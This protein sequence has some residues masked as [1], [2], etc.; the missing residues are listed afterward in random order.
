MRSLLFGYGFTIYRLRAG[1]PAF[2]HPYSMRNS[3]LLVISLGL[4][5]FAQ[6]GV[7]AATWVGGTG[8]WSNSAKWSGG[9][10]TSFADIRSGTA[11][12]TTTQLAHQVEISNGGSVLIDGGSIYT[13]GTTEDYY[14]SAGLNGSGT[15]TVRNGGNIRTGVV[16][17]G[18]FANGIGHGTVTGE[19]SYIQS[20]GQ[21][22]IGQNGVGHVNV[23]DGGALIA[24]AILAVGGFNST[25]STLTVTGEGSRVETQNQLHIGHR[26]K[27]RLTV[28]DGALVEAVGAIHISAHAGSEGRVDVTTGG[29]IEGSEHMV[30]GAF[31][32][33]ELNVTAGG[34]VNLVGM[35]AVAAYME[36]AA[37]QGTVLIGGSGSKV[38]AAGVGIGNGSITVQNGGALVSTP[39]IAVGQG[40]GDASLLVESGGTV[41]A[42]A[43]WI[44]VEDA[45][46]PTPASGQVT[47]QGL[48]SIITTGSLSIGNK[49]DGDLQIKNGGVVNVSGN[50]DMGQTSAVGTL[51]IEGAGSSLSFGERL[52]LWGANASVEVMDGGLLSG[53]AIE[54]ANGSQ[55]TVGKSAGSSSGTGILD[56][57]TIR[58]HLLSNATLNIQLDPASSQPFYLTQDGTATGDAITVET[59]VGVNITGGLAIFQHGNTY[60]GGT[61][62]SNGGALIVQ[63]SG[64]TSATGS[65]L[66]TVGTTGALGGTGRVDGSVVVNGFISSSFGALSSLGTTLNIG[67]NLDLL[68][69]STFGVIGG[70]DTLYSLTVGG[71]ATISDLATLSLNIT[72]TL[73]LNSYTL[74]DAYDGIV[75][76]TAAGFILSGTIPNGFQLVYSEHRVELVRLPAQFGTVTATPEDSAIIIGGTTRVVV[77]VGNSAPTDYASLVGTATGGSTNV[78]G[79]GTAS[80]ASGTTGTVVDTGA[81]ITFTGSIVG[82]ESGTVVVTDPSATGG[83]GSDTFEVTVYGHA[84]ADVSG[85]TLNLGYVH[86][87]YGGPVTSNTVTVTNGEATDFI[88]DLKGSGASS[89]DI[90]VN[91]FSGLAAGESTQ[92]TA[93]LQAGH[94]VGQINETLTY[95]FGDDS[96]LNGAIDQFGSVGFQI[97]GEVY[98]GHGV[99]NSHSG[100]SWGTL[101]SGFGA[102]WQAG[103]GTPG[104]DAAFANTDTA[105]FGT[106]GSGIVTLDGAAPSLRGITFDNASAEYQLREG[107]GGTI[108]LNAGGDTATITNLNGNHLIAVPLD[109]VSD[110]RVEVAQANDRLTIQGLLSGSGSITIS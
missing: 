104:L 10:P 51:V 85:T 100:G 39:G 47:V 53:T 34:E 71:T 40:W 23:E 62:I 64:T 107:T 43:L 67:G 106:S 83:P 102:N 56:V 105:T 2:S 4:F 29:R 3:A 94:G 65:G 9:S 61:T 46:G 86:E 70:A 88:V 20:A 91:S 14:V 108:T 48:N 63:N 30:V 58:G 54:L 26:G 80:V 45:T 78:T 69:T 50:V 21:M 11:S 18:Y 41:A 55:L 31:A 95:Y 92:I 57:E 22:V 110:T 72:D 75:D 99:W 42:G 59:G 93:T 16:D 32:P 17:F 6:G 5:S 35:L 7:H 66:V 97:T 8:D 28:E 1:S 98:S 79:T 19:G 60:D 36:N 73:T 38:D 13:T 33:G 49:N 89:G 76:N 24:G 82:T 109:L 25:E 101:A 90:S 37:S 44:G 84:I 27:G 96:T 12:V 103:G 87:G 15:L 52:M 81:P 74:L 68:S 77:T